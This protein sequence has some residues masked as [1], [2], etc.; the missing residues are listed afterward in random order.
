MSFVP[1]F[2]LPFRFGSDGHAVTVD[3]DTIDDVTACVEAI[4]RTTKG[5]RPEAP[6]FGIT[7][8]SFQ[9][10]P[11]DTAALIE[12]VLEQEPRAVLVMTQNPDQFSNLI[13]DV[14]A[15]VTTAQEVSNG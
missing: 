3:Q 7:D 5:Q 9:L 2:S 4:L 6:D 13:A 14:V 11:I 1:H 10:Q 15:R 8:P 12:E